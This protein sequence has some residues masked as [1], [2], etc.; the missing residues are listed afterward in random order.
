MCTFSNINVYFVSIVPART[1]SHSVLCKDVLIHPWIYNTNELDGVPDKHKCSSAQ[2][3]VCGCVI[4]LVRKRASHRIQYIHTDGPQRVLRNTVRLQPGSLTLQSWWGTWW[5]MHETDVVEVT[6]KWLWEKN[7]TKFTLYLSL[8]FL[9]GWW[10]AD[11][12]MCQG[13]RKKG[14]IFEKEDL[15]WREDITLTHLHSVLNTAGLPL[16][17]GT[18]N[19]RCSLHRPLIIVRIQTNLWVR[20]AD[21]TSMEELNRM[22]V[23][24][25]R[26]PFLLRKIWK[27]LLIRA[28]H[29]TTWGI[30]RCVLVWDG[31]G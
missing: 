5:N 29:P 13:I 24:L 3:R 31:S 12:V 7:F 21:G 6:P 4:S 18:T 19:G 16:K 30:N 27:R 28:A 15:L 1:L 2:R 17:D 8:P 22:S 11:F 14:M 10:E 26:V 23:T 9:G 20:Q 25:S